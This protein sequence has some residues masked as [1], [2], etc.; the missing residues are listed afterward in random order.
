MRAEAMKRVVPPPVF[1]LAALVAGI[2][3]HVFVPIRLFPE[4]WIGH[5][6][7]WPVVAVSLVLFGW[8]LRTFRRAG[9]HPEFER[10]TQTIVSDGPFRFTRNPFYVSMTLLYVG[11][12]LISNSAWPLI[13]LPLPLLGAHYTVRREERYLSEL[14]GDEYEGYRDRVRRWF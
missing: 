9:E 4:Y 13:F 5:P 1:Y 7:G 2:L 8:S 3:V 6:A 11:L 12:A 14:F 10:E